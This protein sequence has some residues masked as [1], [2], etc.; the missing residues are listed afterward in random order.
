MSLVAAFI[1]TIVC[2]AA[3]AMVAVADYLKAGFVLKN[4]AEVHV[5]VR[6]IPYLATLKLAGAAGLTIGLVAMPWLGVAAGVGLT[7]FFVGAIV[8]HIKTGVLYNLAFPT[9]FLLLAITSAGYLLHLA[10]G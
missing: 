3:N 1:T 9:V 4:S 5:P 7:L 2:I 8:V 10:R 6:A